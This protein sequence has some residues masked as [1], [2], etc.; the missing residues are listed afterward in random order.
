M[1]LGQYARAAEEFGEAY[2]LSQRP[3]L[4]FN[5]YSAWERAGQLEQAQSAL[6][7]FLE[8][9][10]LDDARRATLETR[11]AHLRTRAAEQRAAQAESTLDAERAAR[12]AQEEED[13][14][15]RAAEPAPSSSGGVHPAGIGVL[16]GAGVLALSFAVFAPLAAVEDANL[17]SSCG[18]DMPA[19]QC[20]ESQV[21]TLRALS[22]AADASWIGALTLGVVGLVLVLVL[23]PEPSDA[24]AAPSVALLP[25]LDT[26]Y[27]GLAAVGS[28]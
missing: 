4:L 16:V 14:A 23:P 25:Q 9:G 3:E 15:R 21:G 10:E 2:D 20:S 22:A 28:F 17:A 7:R 11:L 8:L 19:A 12:R 18:R 6:E 1:D 5:Q 13:A 26:T 27:A 24:D